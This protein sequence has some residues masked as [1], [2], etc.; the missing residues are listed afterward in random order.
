MATHHLEWLHARAAGW[1]EKHLLAI[2]ETGV[3]DDWEAFWAGF[4]WNP[5]VSGPVLYLRIKEGLLTI[6]KDGSRSHEG[7]LQS[8]AALLLYG[9]VSSTGDAGQRW[10]D[11]SEFRD[12]LLRGGDELRS[13]VLWQFERLLQSTDVA[14]REKWQC[15]AREFFVDVWPRQRSVETPEMTVRLCRVLIAHPDS[16]AALIDIVSPL[17]TTMHD[18]TGLHIHFQEEVKD[19]IQSHSE[20]FLQLLHSVLP[21]DIRYW[22]YGIGD[23]LDMITEADDS[24]RHDSR[25]RELRRRWN[26]R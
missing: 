10:V 6:A 15:Y 25:F 26:A 9:W 24:L 13:H 18:A 19:L 23:A 1:T 22:P 7:H 17:L 12:V 4:F 11:S 2:L 3:K 5:Q 14:E 20:R 8:L 16:F 21:E